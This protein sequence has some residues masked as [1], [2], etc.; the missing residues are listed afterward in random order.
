MF[1]DEEKACKGEETV[2][3]KGERL[4]MKRRSVKIEKACNDD[5]G[6]VRIK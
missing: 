5:S 2:T 6:R 3:K 1:E 4:R